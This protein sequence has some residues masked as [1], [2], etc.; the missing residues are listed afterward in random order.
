VCV[1]VCLQIME[2]LVFGDAEIVTTNS[3]PTPFELE[4]TDSIDSTKLPD[5]TLTVE[6]LKRLNMLLIGHGK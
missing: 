4:S 6:A 3:P 5:F 1:C 2:P